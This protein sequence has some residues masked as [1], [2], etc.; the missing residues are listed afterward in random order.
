MSTQPQSEP[1]VGPTLGDIIQLNDLFHATALLHTAVAT[2]LFDRLVEP[3]SAADVADDMG[4]I[5]RKC[6]VLLDALVA[7]DLLTKDGDR[8]RNTENATRFLTTGSESYV[9][10]IIDHQRLQWQLWGRMGDVLSSEAPIDAQQEL[11]LRRDGAAN[12]AFNR[13]M[14]QLSRDNVADVLTVPDFADAHRVLDLCGGHGRYLAALA[15]KHPGLTGE[16]WDLETARDLAQETFEEF[17]V[18]DRLSFKAQN[19]LEAEAFAGQSADACLLNDCLHYFDET[20][21]R[22]VI[23]NVASILAT[24]GLLVVMTMTLERDWVTPASA[25]GFSLHMMLNTNH[26]GLHPTPWI[27]DVMNQAGFDVERRP[28][29]SLGRYTLLAGRRH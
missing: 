2:R 3:A 29:G 13:A 9:G 4:W 12:T 19:V 22:T 24:G 7:L 18:A 6:R 16:V 25:A 28:V 26:G 10:A 14:V 17:G 1:G 20:E 11:R 21:V 23:G 27:E 8:Y 5:E 15:Q